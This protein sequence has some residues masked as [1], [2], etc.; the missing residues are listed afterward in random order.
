M[1]TPVNP[2]LVEVSRAETVES[3]HRGAAVVVG[4]DGLHST[5]PSRAQALARRSRGYGRRG[6]FWPP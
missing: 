2:I 1:T 6:V 3:L 4:A 5:R